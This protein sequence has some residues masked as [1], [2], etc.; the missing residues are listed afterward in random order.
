[1]KQISVGRYTLGFFP[2]WIGFSWRECGP[3]G[4]VCDLGFVKFVR[5][6]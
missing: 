5:W 4:R 6:S 3:M 2:Y 1:M